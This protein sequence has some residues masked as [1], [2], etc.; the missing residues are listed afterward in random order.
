VIRKIVLLL[1]S[2]L[3]ASSSWAG[4]IEDG[5]RK[6]IEPRMGIKADK[7]SKSPF[8]GLYE[9]DTARGL[10]Y[11]DA[12]GS[13][14]LFN[15]VFV[16]TKSGDN[17]S[18]KRQAQLG[19]FKFSDLPLAD[20]IKTVY[21]DGSRVLVTIEDPNCTFCKRLIPELQKLDNVT[22]YTFLYPVLGD[23]SAVKSRA[24]WCAD[25]R[26]KTWHEF[27]LSGKALPAKTDCASPID[28]NLALAR[29]LRVMGT[30]TILFKSGE[31]VPGLATADQLAQ[32]LAASK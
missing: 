15:G 27:M 30:P 18:E 21:G 2:G 20:A 11:T 1:A 6:A 31:R 4:P 28:R 8:A 10:A 16:D 14:L 24:I 29:K 5:I 26:T 22:V 17:L 19:V 23:D 3:L 9:V 13:F 12:K 32:K 7:I 25:D